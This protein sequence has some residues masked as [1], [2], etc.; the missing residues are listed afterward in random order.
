[1]SVDFGR[2]PLRCRR[3]GTARAQ[4]RVSKGKLMK[5]WVGITDKNWYLFLRDRAPEEVNFW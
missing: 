4:R 1:M 2:L 3:D 5:F